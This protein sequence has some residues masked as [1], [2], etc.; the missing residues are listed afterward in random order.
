MN[1]YGYN[2]TLF[3]LWRLLTS[4]FS[5]GTW[6]GVHVRMYWAA[7]ILMPLIFFSRLA[8]LGAGF[9]LL[10]GLTYFAL[11]FLIIWTHEMGHI[12]C[13]WLYRIRTDKITLGPLGGL[14]HMNSGAGGPREE[15]WIAL[16]GPA[17]HLVWL[18]VFLPIEWWVPG[19]TGDTWFGWTIWYL[20]AT[21]IGLL[22][23]NLLPI[24]PLDGGRVLRALLA[25][26]VHPNLATLW[27]TNVGMVGGGLLIA[28]ALFQVGP[29]GTIA[30]LI[31]LT[32]ILRSLDEKRRARHV[33]VYQHVMRQDP[34]EQD[35]DAWK[36]G[37]ATSG[38]EPRQPGWFARRREARAKQQARARAEHDR[39]LDAQVD[40]VLER[41]SEVGMSG[42][43]DKEKAILKKASDRRRGAG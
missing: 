23:F 17:V 10:L 41:V 2:P 12:A 22:L 19:A 30:L 11:L 42:L 16:A 5:L 35:P 18:V 28:A 20:N 15:L 29:Y 38:A 24:Y 40:A 21:N 32:C 39:A 31:G 36:R 14:A 9:A 25:M 33:L 1:E 27:A 34:W 13:G 8:M 6:F 7:L 4:N 26:R 37:A 3:K 43:S